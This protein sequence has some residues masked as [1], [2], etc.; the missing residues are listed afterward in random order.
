M[1]KS[2]AVLGCTG[3]IGVQALEIAARERERVRIVGLAAGTKLEELEAQARRW[4]PAWLA[5]ER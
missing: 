1:T 3:S 2:L 5:L 4:Q